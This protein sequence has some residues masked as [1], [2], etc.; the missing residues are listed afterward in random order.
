MDAVSCM[1]SGRLADHQLPGMREAYDICYL[2]IEGLYRP[3]PDTGIMQYWK[4][5]ESSKETQ[6]GRW[7]DVST[8]QRR[9]MASSF[10]SWLSTLELSGGIRLRSTVDSGATAGLLVSL[11]NWW[12]RAD[13][14]SFR[15]MQDMVGDGAELSRPAMLR[16]IIALLPRIGWDR[17][18]VLAKRFKSVREMCEAPAAAW[19]IEREIAQGTA[20]KI[21]AVLNGEGA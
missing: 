17:S 20:E 11:L 7:Q 18:G 2:L 1:Y 3:H 14:K 16:R 12:Q 9:L 10:E 19:Y 21:R 13:H 4:W 5:F 15:V 6:C 8:G